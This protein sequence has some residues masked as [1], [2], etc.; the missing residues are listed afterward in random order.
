MT[1]GVIRK[2]EDF[3]KEQLRSFQVE[4]TA[5]IRE[6]YKVDI[7]QA[8]EELANEI[9]KLQ[10]S[11]TSIEQRL[12]AD[13]LQTP[14][15]NN[16]TH[17]PDLMDTP[18]PVSSHTL[19]SLVEDLDPIAQSRIQLDKARAANASATTAVPTPDQNTFSPSG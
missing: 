19:H 2:A 11:V 13:D 3:C 8:C 9:T 1:S 12:N 5:S 6:Q 17:T 16:H 14:P 7:E 18:T 10:D 15:L 4:L